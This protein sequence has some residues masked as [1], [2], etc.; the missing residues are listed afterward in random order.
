MTEQEYFVGVNAR[1]DALEGVNRYEKLME[2]VSS[3][4]DEESF[5][6][7]VEAVRLEYCR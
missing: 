1:L 4:R 7:A 3:A 5:A 2:A 6:V